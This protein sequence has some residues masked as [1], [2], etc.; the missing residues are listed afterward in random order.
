LLRHAGSLN[1]F[2]RALSVQITTRQSLW[3]TVWTDW[4]WNTS[5]GGA[6]LPV[7]PDWL[8]YCGGIVK[9]GK[10]QSFTQS[11]LVVI[12][13]GRE[14]LAHMA[15]CRVCE[16][17]SHYMPFLLKGLYMILYTVEKSRPESWPRRWSI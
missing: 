4:K 8:I 14:E 6:I 10:I 2:H 11:F 15:I 1:Y 5:V 17:P 13:A 7:G 12:G 9:P 3:S 16:Q